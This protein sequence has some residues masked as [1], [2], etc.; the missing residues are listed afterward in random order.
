MPDAK[1]SKKISLDDQ[2]RNFQC[3][4]DHLFRQ[5]ELDPDTAKHPKGGSIDEF[6]FVDL[7]KP[8]ADS[9]L[10][11]DLNKLDKKDGGIEGLDDV[12][13]KAVEAK[14][15]EAQKT[16]FTDKLNAIEAKISADKKSS[17]DRIEIQA[18][19]LLSTNFSG[20]FEE[21]NAK[22][23]KEMVD[24]TSTL[25]EIQNTRNSLSAAPELKDASEEKNRKELL[26][27][28]LKKL[29]DLEKKVKELQEKLP[30]QILDTICTKPLTTDITHPADNKQI[31][32]V[33]AGKVKTIEELNKALIIAKINKFYAGQNTIWASSDKDYRKQEYFTAGNAPMKAGTYRGKEFG[34]ELFDRSIAGIQLDGIKNKL[35]RESLVYSRNLMS[36]VFFATGVGAIFWAMLNARNA[37]FVIQKDGSMGWSVGNI[38]DSEEK[39]LISYFNR[40]QAAS[41]GKPM[42]LNFELK[43]Y[44][45]EDYIKLMS[46]VAR[47][48]DPPLALYLSDSCRASLGP[49]ADRIE[50]L[51]TRKLDSAPT[52]RHGDGPEEKRTH[53]STKK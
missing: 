9:K 8:F 40:Y 2:L 45:T 10:S 37:S 38:F 41:P 53:F 33:E 17:M 27:N 18:Y 32:T 19:K 50:K 48:K 24:L 25:T 11:I 52:V 16:L 7:V 34:Y 46:K 12:T 21:V 44:I 4:F 31:I 30:Q 29:D 20:N 13:K 42:Y 23:W 1:D 5:M 36:V 47:E 35:L 51:L 26:K 28:Q 49:E 43:G 3:H 39:N 14:P 15:F 22:D 6:N